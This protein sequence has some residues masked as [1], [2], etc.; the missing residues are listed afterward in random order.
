MTMLDGTS[1]KLSE[2]AREFRENILE[3][4]HTIEF[5]KL[6]GSTVQNKFIRILDSRVYIYQHKDHEQA[7][8]IEFANFARAC[9]KEVTE[10]CQVVFRCKGGD[11]SHDDDLLPFFYSNPQLTDIYK[12]I[13]RSTNDVHRKAKIDNYLSSIDYV[14]SSRE[15]RG[16][17]DQRFHVDH[18]KYYYNEDTWAKRLFVALSSRYHDLQVQYTADLRGNSCNDAILQKMPEGTPRESLLFYGSPDVIIKHMPIEIHDEEKN[19]IAPYSSHSMIPQKA[20]QL[21]CYIHQMIVAQVLNNVMLDKECTGGVGYGLYIMKASGTSI[22]FKVTMS[23][24]PLELSATACY[25]AQA[26]TAAVCTAI[27]DLVCRV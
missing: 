7:N 11:E 18:N 8:G 25:G 24:A 13:A 2:V 6:S 14:E 1:S 17:D 20:G 12:M 5:S 9:G 27:N 16:D 22:L 19:E 10:V 21:I 3:D 23:E 4:L 15:F 26:L